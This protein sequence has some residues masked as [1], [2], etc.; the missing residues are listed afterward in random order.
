MQCQPIFNGL[1][2]RMALHT[3]TAD[4]ITCHQIT[5]KVLYQGSVYDMAEGLTEFAKGG[6]LALSAASYGRLCEDPNKLLNT[7]RTLE[8]ALAKSKSSAMRRQNA[9]LNL[10]QR[11]LKCVL[12]QVP[13]VPLPFF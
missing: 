13:F 4:A 12:S 6:Q 5:Q 1:R 9:A 10:R 8:Q 3:D 7:K 11:M 2:V